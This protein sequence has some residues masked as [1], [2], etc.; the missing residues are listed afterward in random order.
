[1]KFS[2]KIIIFLFAA[3]FSLNIF[4]NTEEIKKIKSDLKR[5]G[6]KLYTCQ[7][8]TC[9]YQTFR[10]KTGQIPH[11]KKRCKKWYNFFN[12]G[13]DDCLVRVCGESI[14]D[15]K[16]D[17]EDNYNKKITGLKARLKELKK[18]KRRRRRRR[19]RT[20]PEPEP[21]PG[22]ADFP[23]CVDDCTFTLFQCRKSAG[24]NKQQRRNCKH[25]NITCK[26]NCG[27]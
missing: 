11:M 10:C 2:Y 27:S 18:G 24:R 8:V 14:S 5:A 16:K 15:C 25:K 17:C 9:D 3:I 19:E 23:R 7:E 1:M 6:N 12:I 22:P 26:N 13:V 4:P 21:K 20:R